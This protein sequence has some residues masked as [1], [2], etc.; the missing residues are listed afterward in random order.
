MTSYSTSRRWI[1]AF[2]YTAIYSEIVMK[3]KVGMMHLQNMVGMALTNQLGF[4]IM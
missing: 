1:N 4:K 2:V 3:A